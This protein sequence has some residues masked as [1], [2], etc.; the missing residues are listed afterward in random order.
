[1]LKN[2][3]KNIIKLGIAFGLI[4]WLVES[5]KLDF[6][7]L[8]QVF[9]SPLTILAI[10]AL[11]LTDHFI[12]AVR[13]KLILMRKASKNLSTFK[14][15]ISNWIGIFFNAVLPGS[16]TG[17]V[18]KVFYLQD[19][20]EKLDKKFLLVAVFM[21][22]VM[23]LIGLVTIGG[24]I[25]GINYSTLSSLSN[26]VKI[27]VQVNLFILLCVVL[28]L[29]TLF[30][31]QKLPHQIAK[32]FRDIKILGNIVKKLEV[33]WN[34]LCLFRKNIIKLLVLSIFIQAFAIII[35][36]YIAEPY[37]AGEFTLATAFTVL[38]AGMIS[39][40]IPIAPGGLGV[41]HVVFEKLLAFF[42][43]SN[44]AD[45]FNIYFFFVLFTNLTGVVPYMLY[46]KKSKEIKK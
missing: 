19:L 22:R 12:V 14:I 29:L 33:L 46:R 17:D 2:I 4:Y 39:I 31:Y 25:S 9:S 1:M 8:K 6:S 45:L 16:V 37:A 23:G 24:I 15:F 7:L 21:D 41:G 11:M 30:F 27:L 42:N 43:I 10:T 26:D 13:L 28:T 3:V 36:W 20:D 18:I 32:P 35:F 34:D 38:P 44:G 40:A 5:G